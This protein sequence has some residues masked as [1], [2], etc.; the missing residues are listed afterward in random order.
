[1]TRALA[2][3]LL[4]LLLVSLSAPSLAQAPARDPKLEGRLDLQ[5][6]VEATELCGPRTGEAGEATWSVTALRLVLDRPTAREDLLWL[7]E[8]AQPA[9][10]LYALCGLWWLDRPTYEARVGAF[11]QDRREVSYLAEGCCGDRRSVRSIVSR[12]IASGSLPRGLCEHAWG[13]PRAAWIVKQPA[14]RRSPAFW[15]AELARPA[16]QRRAAPDEV[17][18]ALLAFGSAGADSAL[19]LAQAPGRDQRWVA[20]EVL[21]SLGAERLGP[22]ASAV[23]K[24]LGRLLLDPDLEVRLTA[25][26]GLR[27]RF[28]PWAHVA[29]EEALR[30]LER[31][32]DPPAEAEEEQERY[33]K[34]LVGWIADLEPAALEP[35]SRHASPLVRAQVAYRLPKDAPRARAALRALLAAP[36]QGVRA[37]A[38][39]SLAGAQL[40]PQEL[41]ALLAL[42]ED[43]S[44]EVR[45]SAAGALAR[46][47]P[48]SGPL[49]RLELDRALERSREPGLRAELAL[50]RFRLAGVSEGLVSEL[51]RG[52]DGFDRSRR[53]VE[54]L[55]EHPALLPQ[56]APCLR[57]E[58]SYDE[59]AGALEVLSRLG[60]RGRSLAP[61][62]KAAF[63]GADEGGALAPLAA[64]VLL[65]IAGD[66]EPALAWVRGALH[67]SP[68]EALALADELGP[69]A[70]PLGDLLV[71][72]IRVVRHGEADLERAARVLS[73]LGPDPA[74]RAWRAL[75]ARVSDADP[76]LRLSA[77]QGLGS[78]GW[79]DQGA[80]IRAVLAEVAR[81]E[82]DPRVL[83][84]A[85]RALEQHAR[86]A[87]DD[88]ADEDD[89]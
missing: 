43:R 87:Q 38:A 28:G 6:L 33:V 17:G 21:S 72:W 2:L 4:L 79:R 34:L 81:R 31:L 26:C 64:R 56:L 16:G 76:E 62:V 77:V 35:F 51:L 60:P 5:I 85:R 42:L 13:R 74:D 52:L 63:E 66:G 49:P 41:R 18:G 53:V 40:Q 32:P 20:A 84:A 39:E 82:T 75:A 14:E 27:W 23:A 73:R 29:R 55:E 71:R 7:L 65:R 68:R 46:A 36:E 9:G 61:E 83:A 44:A 37:A 19:V 1:M 30:A 80:E 54:L 67:G 57:A 22:R 50:A 70:R 15:V 12:D 47:Q 3:L 86:A 58:R 10:R 89:D 59:V 8:H 88:G 25:I 78:L 48:P 11:L 24:V 69:A 45:L